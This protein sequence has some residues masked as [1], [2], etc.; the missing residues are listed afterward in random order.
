MTNLPHNSGDRNKK[1]RK[2][3][4]ERLSAWM[5]KYHNA[6]KKNRGIGYYALGWSVLLVITTILFFSSHI[7]VEISFVIALV[8]TSFV[9]LFIEKSILKWII[10]V[11]SIAVGLFFLNVYYYKA[12]PDSG[13]VISAKGVEGFSHIDDFKEDNLQ[14]KQDEVGEEVD[15]LKNSKRVL[16][17]YLDR[18][19]DW[20]AILL[21]LIS[22][23]FVA[24]TWKSQA[25]TQKNTQRITPDIQKGILKDFFRHSYK[26]LIVLTAIKIRLQQE[27]YDKFYPAEYHI[28]KLQTE[29]NAIYPEVFV[30][31]DDFCGRLHEMKLFV[32]NGNLEIKEVINHIKNPNL[33]LKYKERGINL[34]GKRIM[35]ILDR[36]ATILEVMYGIK[37][38]TELAEQIKH[39]MFEGTSNSSSEMQQRFKEEIQAIIEDKGTDRSVRFDE[40]C[41]INTPGNSIIDYSTLV[42]Y[43]Y[44]EEKLNDF[45]AV[46]VLTNES[47]D[48]IT[49]TP[50][51]MGGFVKRINAEIFKMLPE[52]HLIPFNKEY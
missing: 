27:G 9:A 18:K 21:A 5:R 42:A 24:Y 39:Y 3:F 15:L 40:L 29:E 50:M 22:L 17:P 2:S 30:D 49:R 46:S 35:N 38:K 32:R 13:I 19:S 16:S 6:L 14:G 31:N 11:I 23:I 41:A 37:D 1:E 47:T 34:I 26:N 10:F 7:T 8:A 45:E 25:E 44:P 33:D 52:I 43:L 48:T 28:T 20:F 51:T 12:K 36:T 4:M